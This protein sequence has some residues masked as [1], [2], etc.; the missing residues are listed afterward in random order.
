VQSPPSRTN[1]LVREGGLCIISHDFNRRR[2]IGSNLGY[3]DER[4]TSAAAEQMTIEAKISV[5]H[6]KATID[7]IAAAVIQQQWLDDRATI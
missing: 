7:R 2:S 5:S 4:L 6:N 1:K 3:V